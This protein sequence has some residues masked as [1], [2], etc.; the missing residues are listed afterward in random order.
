MRP[1]RNRTPYKTSPAI[2]VC[3]HCKPNAD[4]TVQDVHSSGK[5]RNGWTETSGV[6]RPGVMKLHPLRADTS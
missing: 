6:L 2:I 1:L 4:V 3:F 5:L